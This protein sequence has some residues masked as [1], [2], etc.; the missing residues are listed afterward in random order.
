MV[1]FG[2]LGPLRAVDEDGCARVLAPR[3]RAVLAC[4]LLNANKVVPTAD[5]FDALWG[6]APP[7]SARNTL[8]GHVKSLRTHLAGLA[9]RVVTRDPGYLMTVGENE[10]DLD[11]FGELRAHGHA[12]AQEGRWARA[13]EQF[14][15]ALA[16]WRG[17]ALADVPSRRLREGE[18]SR[19]DELRLATLEQRVD[20][21]LRCGKAS[22]TV[23][24]LRSLVTAHPWRERFHA[25]LMTA[26]YQSS[27]QADALAA[28]QR[29]HQVLRDEL[30]I[31][32]GPELRRLHQQVLA[33]DP[34][35]TSAEESGT[36]ALT[37]P[38]SRARV[39]PAQLPADVAD[40]TG[41]AEEAARLAALL[42]PPASATRPGALRVATVIGMPGVGKTALAVHVAHALRETYPDGQLF[43]SLGGATRPP[44]PGHV[45]ARFLRDLGADEVAVPVDELER[46]TL[47]RSMVA[48]KRVLV[49]L[50]D[51]RDSAQVRPLLPGTAGSAVIVTSRRE[52]HDLEGACRTRLSPLPDADARAMLAALTG[53]ACLDGDPAAASAIVRACGGLPLAIRIAG[54]RCARYPAWGLRNFADR[55]AGERDRLDHL[56]AGDLAVR[57][58]FAASY[59]ALRAGDGE[60]GL[61]RS[62]RLLGLPA[63]PDIAVPA[64][65]ALFGVPGCQAERLLEHLVDASILE[66][67]APGRYRMHDLV[68]SFAAERAV[69]DE[70]GPRRREALSRYLTWYVHASR[71]ADRA[72][73][74]ASQRVDLDLTDPPAD[75]PTFGAPPE[76][77]AWFQVEHP[78][79]VAAA[80]QAIGL[81]MH[82]IAERL[83]LTIGGFLRRH[84]HWADYADLLRGGLASARAHGDRRSEAR[85][86]TN[87]GLIAKVTGDLGRAGEYLTESLAIRRQLGEAGAVAAALGNLGSLHS[88]MGDPQGAAPLHEEALTVARAAGIPYYE[89]G[90]LCALGIL[91]A[92]TGQVS[93]A[94][95]LVSRS[96]E[97]ARELG[98]ARRLAL[99][100]S[101]LGTVHL[102]SGRY[103]AAAACVREAN[104]ALRVR[105]ELLGTPMTTDSQI[106]RDRTTI[107][108]MQQISSHV[109][110][111]AGLP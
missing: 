4:L 93:E 18:A 55:L 72:T 6:A 47:Y 71:N 36:A 50:D 87:L 83:P 66:G 109:R 45:L 63:G 95:D 67:Y 58:C 54:A 94:A 3:Q 15:Q 92:E 96:A 7:P 13:A 2:V 49:V 89:A 62:L 99:A 5:L 39:V 44:D 8:Q 79:L 43:A 23:G 56:E 46:V 84:G 35:L 30:G 1:R 102:R 68:K 27:R 108:V 26:L 101:W 74:P 105:G 73:D 78:N 88:A 29:A 82:D 11:V 52:L 12:A 106:P 104:D 98:D 107:S 57:A 80:R 85:F 69:A 86:L 9:D 100:L 97:I 14:R 64:A 22:E 10:L 61:A 40:F 51:A 19:L 32:P 28:Y 25:Q 53:P 48:G 34:E 42:A 20:A 33:A 103:H 41:R 31:E 21:D 111:M 65:A 16:L 60:F 24:E 110:P 90:E 77:T 91:R 70:P 38:A 76:A 81:D 37:G 75:L 17:D 59:A